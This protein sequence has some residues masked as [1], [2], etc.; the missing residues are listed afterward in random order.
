MKS[1]QCTNQSLCMCISELQH[2]TSPSH[3]DTQPCRK[4][5][6]LLEIQPD[7]LHSAVC[8]HQ[9]SSQHVN[10]REFSFLGLCVQTQG[11]RT[12]H[13]MMQ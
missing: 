1:L 11:L 2:Q 5:Q 6:E 8:I 12:L 4:S 13:T 9:Y 10:K 3:E 7:S